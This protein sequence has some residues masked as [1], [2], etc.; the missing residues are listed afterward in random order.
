[1]RR[2]VIGCILAC[3]IIISATASTDEWTDNLKEAQQQAKKLDRYLLINFSGSDWCSWCIKLDKEVFSQDAFQ[4]YASDQLVLVVADFP[5]SKE[6]PEDLKAQNQDLAKKYGI[7]G[8]PTVIVLSPDGEV[9]AQ[10]GYRP[11]GAD[12][13]VAHLKEIIRKHKAQQ[14]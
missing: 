2:I 9:A 4:T 11:G 5:R 3:A 8:F 7:R 14:K 13:Y 1:M 6:Q 12:D 10:T